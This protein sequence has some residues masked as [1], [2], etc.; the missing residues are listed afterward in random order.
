M[1]RDAW[2]NS[3]GDH[4][5]MLTR[6]DPWSNGPGDH[7]SASPI[8]PWINGTAAGDHWSTLARLVA[9]LVITRASPNRS[10]DLQPR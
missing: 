7:C 5:S 9:A 1:R 10:L 8:D 6:R 3:P 2:S 4:W